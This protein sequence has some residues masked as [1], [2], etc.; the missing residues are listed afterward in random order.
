MKIKVR[1]E[2]MQQ[3]EAEVVEFTPLQDFLF[4]VTYY[5]DEGVRNT[6]VVDHKRLVLDSELKDRTYGL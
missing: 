4:E 2:Y 1:D 6:V 3:Y 5:D